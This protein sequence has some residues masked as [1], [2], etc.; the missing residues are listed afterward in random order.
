[1]IRR[2]QGEAEFESSITRVRE[3]TQAVELGRVL[4]EICVL[5]EHASPN[6]TL[7]IDLHPTRVQYAVARC[8]GLSGTTVFIWASEHR[9][10]AEKRA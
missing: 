8:D 7:K 3:L 4:V 9:S 2:E 6:Q 10:D 1:M 5:R